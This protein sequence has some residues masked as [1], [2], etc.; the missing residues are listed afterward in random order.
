M[1]IDLEDWYHYYSIDTWGSTPSRLEG[2]TSWI[3]AELSKRGIK[4]TFFVLGYIAERHPELIRRIWSE[5]HEI[6]IHGYDHGLVFN[7]SPLEF[8]EEIKKAISVVE[9]TTGVR[10]DLFRAPSFSIN[11]STDW[12]WEILAD[13][14]I[15][16]DSSLFAAWRLEGGSDGV[17]DSAFKFSLQQGVQMVEYPIIPRKI[18]PLRIPYS[19]G[20]YFRLLPITLI[21]RW[22]KRSAEPVIFYFH[23]RDFDPEVPYIEGLGHFRNKLVHIGLDSARGKFQ[24]LLDSFKFTNLK[25]AFHDRGIQEHNYLQE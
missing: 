5:G 25:T 13:N 6:G 20:A 18:G 10:P 15:R 12:V 8:N 16:R 24:T 4:A 14:G 22:L 19:G 9:K 17:P 1:T 3:L 21:T 2:P 23:P 7:K 11:R